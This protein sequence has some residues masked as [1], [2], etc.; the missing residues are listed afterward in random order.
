MYFWNILLG[1]SIPK[2]LDKITR[3]TMVMMD[4]WSIEVKNNPLQDQP[5][6]PKVINIILFF[7]YSSKIYLAAFIL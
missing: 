5:P 7:F 1:E 3:A 2:L 6:H 4:R